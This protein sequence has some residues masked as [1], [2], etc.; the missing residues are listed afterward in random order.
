MGVRQ[1][2]L[3]G[4]RMVRQSRLAAPHANE[5]HDQ[6]H[7]EEGRVHIRRGQHGQGGVHT[8]TTFPRRRAYHNE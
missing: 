4:F 7:E 1:W 3:L 2:H 5:R 8:T 6:A